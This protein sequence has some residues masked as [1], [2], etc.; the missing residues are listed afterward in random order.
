MDSSL[1]LLGPFS[2]SHTNGETEAAL[3]QVFITVFQELF[4]DQISDVLNYGTPIFGSPKVVE[5]FT[6]QDGLVVLRR[7]DSSDKMMRIIYANWSA[8]AS[9]RGL[10]FLEFVLQMLWPDQ[11]KLHRLYHS[12]SQASDYPKRTTKLKAVDTFLTSRITIAVDQSINFEEVTALAPTIFRLVPANIVAELTAELEFDA[13]DPIGVAAAY[14]A[15]AYADFYESGAADSLP[16]NTAWHI[17]AAKEFLSL[18]RVKYLGIKLVADAVVQSWAIVD[19]N[20]QILA[21]LSV[22]AYQSMDEL[23]L[24]IESLNGWKVLYTWENANNRVK[25]NFIPNPVDY[26]AI[27][28]VVFERFNATP[29]NPDLAPLNAAFYDALNYMG[30]FVLNDQVCQFDP[31][32][33]FIYTVGSI[34]TFDGFEAAL[35]LYTAD[36]IANNPDWAGAVLGA[37]TLDSAISTT[38]VKTYNQAYSITTVDEAE[39]ST[40]TDYT[41]TITIVMDYNPNQVDDGMLVDSAELD[42]MVSSIAEDEEP[43]SVAPRILKELILSAYS[44]SVEGVGNQLHDSSIVYYPYADIAQRISDLVVPPNGFDAT[45]EQTAAAQVYVNTIAETVREENVADQLVLKTTVLAMFDANVG[46]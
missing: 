15:I 33:E 46:T 39:V 4:K 31:S 45:P 36:Q 17:K 9:K 13:P 27:N 30:W 14:Y 43:Y 37:A 25:T 7:P 44:Y 19:L 8:M 18:G 10:S 23:D 6:K 38:F 12:K 11:W 41:V 42:L 2:Q 24:V 34:T 28:T 32:K 21:Q 1:D 5:R 29:A 22:P 35:N 3:Q 16:T 40:T 26:A 20:A